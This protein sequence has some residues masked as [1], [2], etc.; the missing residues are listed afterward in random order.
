MF[1][2]RSESRTIMNNGRNTM[3]DVMNNSSSRIYDVKNDSKFDIVVFRK[4]IIKINEMLSL[5]RTVLDDKTRT[6]E[7]VSTAQ[8]RRLFH[9]LIYE[10][11]SLQ[12]IM[13]FNVCG[14]VGVSFGTSKVLSSL[15][16]TTIQ[17]CG[18]F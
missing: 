5:E 15:F 10:F 18:L 4:S 6:W 8:M 17:V 2:K 13:Q 1:S 11:E 16:L 12:Q 3:S 7:T 14:D 9:L